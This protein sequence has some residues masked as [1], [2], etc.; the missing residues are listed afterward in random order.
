[1]TGKSILQMVISSVFLVVLSASPILATTYCN[2]NFDDDKDVD[3]TDAATFKT[4][5]GRN[6]YNNPCPS[7]SVWNIFY[8]G[9]DEVVDWVDHAPNPR[10]AVFDVNGNNGTADP[11]R[12]NEDAVLNKDTGLIWPRNASYLVEQLTWLDAMYFCRMHAHIF[13]SFKGWRLPTPEELASHVSTTE[14]GP[15]MPVG[16][17]FLYVQSDYYWTSTSQESNSVYA[18]YVH[19]WTGD[20][21]ADREPSW[22]GTGS[23]QHR[24][25]RRW[26]RSA[27]RLHRS[28]TDV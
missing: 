8:S 3:G 20:S 13:G 21:Q 19:F 7:K 10:F 6:G 27:P 15:A 11:D 17:P 1:M 5:F 18:R 4:D 22:R 12:Y 25:R 14:T 26:S 2:G 9:T 24:L 28:I 23:W 16:H